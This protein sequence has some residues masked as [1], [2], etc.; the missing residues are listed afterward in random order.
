MKLPKGSATG[1][2]HTR[3]TSQQRQ[4]SQRRAGRAALS[5]RTEKAPRIQAPGAT[6][7]RLPS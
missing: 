4:V 1:L 6:I 7:G 5:V 3:R 2:E